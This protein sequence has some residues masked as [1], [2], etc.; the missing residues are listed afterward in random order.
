[1]HVLEA[2]SGFFEG[3]GANIGR[4][5]WISSEGRAAGAA[6][7]GFVR[8]FFMQFACSLRARSASLLPSVPPIAI[9][10]EFSAWNP[11]WHD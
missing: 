7:P 10:V 6:K 11:N 8:L 5:G 9:F 3:R 4:T 1:M 2:I